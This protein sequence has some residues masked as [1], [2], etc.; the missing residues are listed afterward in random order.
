[1]LPNFKCI[2]TNSKYV[3]LKELSEFESELLNM[4][5][6]FENR[7]ANKDFIYMIGDEVIDVRDIDVEELFDE[8]NRMMCGSTIQSEFVLDKSGC[9]NDRKGDMKIEV[10]RGPT[11]GGRCIPQ[12]CARLKGQRKRFCVWID[13]STALDYRGIPS[14]TGLWFDSGTSTAFGTTLTTPFLGALSCSNCFRL[15]LNTSTTSTLVPT[16]ACGGSQTFTAANVAGTTRG[17]GNNTVT[18]SCSN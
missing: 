13:Y 3:Y 12:I 1:M 6:V 8:Q 11:F 16:I 2:N 15:R 9:K 5:D 7:F 17:I 14:A 10:K 18:A 4:T